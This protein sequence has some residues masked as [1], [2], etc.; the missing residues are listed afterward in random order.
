MKPRRVLT[1][2]VITACLAIT[3]MSAII[4]S[5]YEPVPALPEIA[6]EPRPAII[7]PPPADL[8]YVDLPP[9]LPDLTAF[10]PV[11]LPTLPVMVMNRYIDPFTGE[12]VGRMDYPTQGF[13]ASPQGTGLYCLWG[14]S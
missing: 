11:D 2:A 10:E 9:L 12:E 13:P 8:P 7:V 4:W 6:L 3:A 1:V 5:C 14:G